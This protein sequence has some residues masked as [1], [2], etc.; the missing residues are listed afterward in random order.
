[1]HVLKQNDSKIKKEMD[2]LAATKPRFQKFLIE[3]K[4]TKFD[5]D[6]KTF[7]DLC[8]GTPDG[9][10]DWLKE[11]T[12]SHSPSFN[13]LPIVHSEKLKMIQMPDYANLLEAHE[14]LT[15]AKEVYSFDIQD[16]ELV[17]SN[18]A[19]QAITDKHTI[20]GDDK[21]KK[22]LDGCNKIKKEAEYL[23]DTFGRNPLS[24][25]AIII[26]NG[27]DDSISV[28]VDRINPSIK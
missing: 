27:F 17:V 20:Y 28:S 11:K 26:V 16:G 3:L 25:Q 19:E 10:L 1:M 4:K 6:T 15:R 9:L 7:Q 8:Y 13:K 24:A 18:E 14:G 23:R 2:S 22:Y 5:F 12:L 21:A